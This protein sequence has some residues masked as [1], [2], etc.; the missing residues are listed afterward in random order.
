MSTAIVALLAT[1]ATPF[2][3]MP[4]MTR[5][6]LFLML[7]HSVCHDKAHQSMGPHVHPVNHVHMMSEETETVLETEKE[8]FSRMLSAPVGCPTKA[9]A[10]VAAAVPARRAVH[11]SK[12]EAS[13]YKTSV[14]V[15]A[16]PPIFSE[17]LLKNIVAGLGTPCNTSA[18]LR[19]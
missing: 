13:S 11:S 5:C 18:P 17:N 10:S 6:G 14:T 15:Q 1:L 9:C 8:Q 16:S 19:I 3:S 4:C 7:Q 2:A 12:L